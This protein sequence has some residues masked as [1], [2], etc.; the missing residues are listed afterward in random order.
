MSTTRRS[1]LTAL[2]ATTTAVSSGWLSLSPLAPRFLTESIACAADQQ[3]GEQILVVIQLSG[4]NDGLNTIVPYRDDGYRSQRSTL[5]LGAE[6]VLKIDDELGFHPSLKG[7]AKLWENKQLAIVQGVG[8]PNPNRSHFESMDIWNTAQAKPDKRQGGWL[9]R[10]I[11][12]Q[13]VAREQA[14][15]LALHIG[16]ETQPLA[17]AAREI[18]T[19]SIRTLERFKLDTQGDMA[20]RGK[21]ETVAR[22]PRDSQ[23][24][25]LKFV[26]QRATSAL[27]ASERLEAAAKDY[28]TS[29]TY[30]TTALATKLKSIAQLISAGLTTRVYYVAIDGWDTH[31]L[32]GPAH[33][34]LL[35]QLGDAVAA[36]TEDLGQQGHGDRV[37]TLMF[38]EFGRR[39]AENGSRGTDH[40]AAAPLFVAGG[41]VQAGLIGKHPS[42]SDLDDGDLKHHT[43]FR[44][45]YAGLL[46][47][48]LKWPSAPI[49]GPDITP[50]AVTL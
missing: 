13:P 5:L 33:A 16:E 44:A 22:L 2:S 39:V 48:W 27:A 35:Q 11:D 9:G 14:D 18:N 49:L 50:L 30:P 45:V 24:D 43:D 41:K 25:L 1:F 17:L 40:G 8:Y 31:S 47:H 7:F 23:N 28:R 38:S 15:S 20:L 34:A 4:G 6:Q 21:I 12:K 29:V 42:L 32:Q 10:A 3:R 46:E 36:F 19:P 37:A 26:Q